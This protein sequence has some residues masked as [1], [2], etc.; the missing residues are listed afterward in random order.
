MKPSRFSKKNR[1]YT[2]WSKNVK[3][4]R[5]TPEIKQDAGKAAEPR[6]EADDNTAQGVYANLAGVSHTETEFILDFLFL[7]PDAPPQTARVR[8]RIISSM[9]HAKRFQ[10]ALQENIKKYEDRFGPIHDH[11]KK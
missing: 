7:Q 4:V 11:D 10:R 6:I 3:E 9:V 5:I 2:R 1:Q 8:A